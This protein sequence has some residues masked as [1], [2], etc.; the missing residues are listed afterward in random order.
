L[1]LHN[2]VKNPDKTIGK[3]TQNAVP[4]HLPICNISQDLAPFQKLVSLWRLPQRLRAYPS[5]GLD[6]LSMPLNTPEA[7]LSRKSAH[8]SNIGAEN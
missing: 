3:R 2:P 8:I 5:A 7:F 1:Y 6:E 4:T